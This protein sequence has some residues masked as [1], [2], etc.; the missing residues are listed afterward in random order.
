MLTELLVGHTAEHMQLWV[1]CIRFI[2]ESAPGGALGF[3]TYMEL[4]IWLVS[5][6]IFRP[7]RLRWLFFTLC[8][9]GASVPSFAANDELIHGVQ[10]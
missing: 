1:D 3:F 2:K 9:F 4:T 7:S 8:G 5:F 10:A 6:H